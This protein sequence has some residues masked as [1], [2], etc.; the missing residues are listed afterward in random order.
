MEL[1]GR[2]V[3]EYLSGRNSLRDGYLER[4]DVEAVDGEPVIT[5]RFR[6]RPDRDARWVEM[7]LKDVKEVCFSH[8]SDYT[9]G[10][11]PFVTCT[12]TSEEEFYL[13][14]DPFQEGAPPSEADHD[15]FRAA[16]VKLTI[17][18]S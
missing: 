1:S 18:E 14:L 12:W 13:S 3:A 15:I 5:L 11:L 6:M 16:S 2:D 9:F 17:P 10:E 4:L 7:V 8:A